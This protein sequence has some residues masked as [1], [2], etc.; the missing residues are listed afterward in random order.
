MES[1]QTIGS[2]GFV[3][4][5]ILACIAT[6]HRIELRIIDSSGHHSLSAHRSGRDQ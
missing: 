4:L 3:L 5:A 6:D 1:Y 2:I